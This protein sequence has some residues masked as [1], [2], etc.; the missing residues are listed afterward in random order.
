[1]PAADS[2]V[3]HRAEIVVV[4]N[5]GDAGVDHAAVGQL[6]T[7]VVLQY[8]VPGAYARSR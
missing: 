3:E 8:L 5:L 1:M 4:R 2:R 7:D 6:V